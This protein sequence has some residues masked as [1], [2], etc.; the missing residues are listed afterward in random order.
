MLNLFLEEILFV[1]VKLRIF[2]YGQLSIKNDEV[3][4]SFGDDS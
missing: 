1:S 3:N 4:L 2:S